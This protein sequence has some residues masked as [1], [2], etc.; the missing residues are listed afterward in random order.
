MNSSGNWEIRIQFICGFTVLRFSDFHIE[1]NPLFIIP[2][3]VIVDG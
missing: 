3:T 1:P 2:I